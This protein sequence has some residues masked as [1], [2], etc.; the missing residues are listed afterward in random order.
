MK[1]RPLV[2]GNWKM[3][4]T[5]PET[6][7]W[8]DEILRASSGLT[9]AD[10]AV[11]PPYTVLSEASRL[12]TGTTIRLGAQNLHWEDRGAFT[13]EISGPMIA[14]AGCRYVVIGHSER[15]Q[16]FGETDATVRKRIAA[17]LRSGLR[18]IVCVGET[19]AERDAG[20]TLEVVDVQIDGALTGFS[21]ESIGGLVF[22][23]EPVWAI[24]TGRTASPEEAQD[25]QEAIRR[26]L[27]EKI[28][29]S[30]AACVIILYGGSV[31]PANAYA[32]FRKQDIDGF[33][34]GGASLEASSFIEIAKESIR[35][36]KEVK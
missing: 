8:I 30:A 29:K 9:E 17:A 18:P 10:L 2:A 22:A 36:Y 34:V 25:V 13:G 1:N 32:L 35:A 27:Q 15:R 4:M 14:D 12:L 26:R 31:K 16:W 11:L 33:L 20:R 6:R 3:H 19:S 5:L 23:Y 24:G 21:A 28:G 7:T